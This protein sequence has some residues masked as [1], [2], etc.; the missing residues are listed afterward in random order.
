MQSEYSNLREPYSLSEANSTFYRWKFIFLSIICIVFSPLMIYSGIS[1]KIELYK[2][3]SKI[4]Q[5][6]MG[7]V[8]SDLNI[9]FTVNKK[10]YIFKFH[11][12]ESYL[13]TNNIGT[14]VAVIYSKKDPS[15]NHLKKKDLNHWKWL[16]FGGFI[17]LSIGVFTAYILKRTK[18][19]TSASLERKR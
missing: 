19:P 17:I 9:E 1:D 12:D 15:L 5:V 18:K 6:T 13:S 10:P 16:I 8:N 4:N 11:P 7:T 2:L 14:K 3:E